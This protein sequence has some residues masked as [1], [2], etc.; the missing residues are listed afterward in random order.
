MFIILLK[1]IYIA[2]TD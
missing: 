2:E 1:V